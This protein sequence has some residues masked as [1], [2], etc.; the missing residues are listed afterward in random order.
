MDPN[1]PNPGNGRLSTRQFENVARTLNEPGGGLSIKAAGPGVGFP[2]TE[3]FM[4]GMPGLG[5]DWGEGQKVQPEDIES[6]T[7]E[8]IETLEQ[9]DVFLGG[10]RGSNP[11]RASVDVSRRFPKTEQGRVSSRFEA[12][13]GNQ[14]AIGEVGPVGEYQ[15]DIDN[16]FYLPA[17]KQEPREMVT[18]FESAWASSEK[19]EEAPDPT[20]MAVWKQAE[21]FP[22]I[23]RRRRR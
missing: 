23:A 6:F 4:V 10:W 20:H 15:G 7:E 1:T 8:N 2:A 19:P 21:T 3:G 18:L 22:K 9:P 13:R 14:E 17:E 11:D 16:P 5:K 12:T